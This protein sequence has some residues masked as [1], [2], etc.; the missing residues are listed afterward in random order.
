MRR[1]C[2]DLRTSL[3]HAHS[4]TEEEL[5]AYWPGG[6]ENSDSKGL[7][8]WLYC[9][10]NLM[11]FMARQEPA[12][13]QALLDVALARQLAAQPMVV[14]T[15]G[16]ETRHVYPKSY[17][18]LRFLDMLDRELVMLI[19]RARVADVDS[20]DGAAV[21]M[22]APLMES[23]A[24]RLWAWILTHPAPGLPFDDGGE[25]PDPPAWTQT[26]SATDLL[27]LMRAHAQVNARD[28]QIIA[29]AFPQDAGG[30]E[31]RLSLA[32]FLGTASDALG[33]RPFELMRKWSLG[34]L[35]AQRVTAA[36][37]ARASH[38][39]AKAHREVA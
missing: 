2:A 33:V 34:E 18:A 8:A 6:S 22:L 20:G 4:A 3:L 24:V 39:A 7:G 36:E 31:T 15:T 25:A 1:R 17:H 21:A 28:L 29:G 9:W 12:R 30:V 38:A 11:R 26:L 5:A 14:P 35:F 37:S 16:G 10:G 23:L 19:D 13:E 32:G 27:S